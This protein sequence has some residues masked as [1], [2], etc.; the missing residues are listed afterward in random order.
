[1]ASGCW[2]S[3]TTAPPEVPRETPRPLHR[4]NQTPRQ[5][6]GY[7][8]V[9]LREVR[10]RVSA[11]AHN[12]ALL[13]A[14]V[15]LEAV[16]QDAAEEQMMADNGEMIRVLAEKVM[17]WSA[18]GRTVSGKVHLDFDAPGTISREWWPNCPGGGRGWNPLTSWADAGMLLDKMRADGHQWEIRTNV[19]G[20]FFAGVFGGGRRGLTYALVASGPEAIALAAYRAVTEVRDGE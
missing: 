18:K 19:E 3:I 1:M 6:P 10:R 20:G 5:A 9:R 16:V 13:R 7:E 17:G 14:T 12:A 8:V 11:E 15:P 4:Q 2:L